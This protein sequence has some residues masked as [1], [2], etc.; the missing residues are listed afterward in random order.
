MKERR[1]KELEEKTGAIVDPE[2]DEPY[3]GLV[4]NNN[5]YTIDIQTM[6]SQPSND[7]Y[8]CYLA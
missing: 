2:Y 4:T 1:D 5:I 6:I 7:L 3:H 8:V